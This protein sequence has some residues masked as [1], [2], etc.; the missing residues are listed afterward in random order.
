MKPVIDCR[1][2]I[3]TIIFTLFACAGMPLKDYNPRSTNEEEIIE[4]I[5][6]HE[7]AWNEQNLSGFMATYHRSALIEDGC[8]GPLIS[9]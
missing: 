4:V 3:L 1:A 7:K 9:A 2:F 6:Q 8:N 5:T